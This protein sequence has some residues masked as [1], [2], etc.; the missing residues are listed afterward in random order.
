MT[1]NETVPLKLYGDSQRFMQ[2]MINL[3]SN[4][5]KFTSCGDCITIRIED[6]PFYDKKSQSNSS[7]YLKLLIQVFD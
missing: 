6:E 3:L 2:V 4:A 1:V 7:E 5:I